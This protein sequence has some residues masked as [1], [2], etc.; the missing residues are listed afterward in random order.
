MPDL[1]VFVL[2]ITMFAVLGFQAIMRAAGSKRGRE[3]PW[4][5][6]FHAQLPPFAHQRIVRISNLLLGVAVF[7]LILT[8]G[9]VTYVLMSDS[10]DAS[11][12]GLALTSVAYL[13]ISARSMFVTAAWA[14][15]DLNPA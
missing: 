2:P 8:G 5:V 3:L 13:M 14:Y 10:Y 11:V 9:S 15:A 6:P 7:G 12:I 4:S 1:A